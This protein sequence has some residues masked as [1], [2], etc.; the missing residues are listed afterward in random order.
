MLY[1]VKMIETFATATT[2]DAAAQGGI[3]FMYF[4]LP[5]IILAISLV[6]F[7]FWCVLTTALVIAAGCGS[8]RGLMNTW[9]VILPY[10]G[11]VGMLLGLGLQA[12]RMTSGGGRL[13]TFDFTR[14]Q[15]RVVPFA[16]ALV[17]FAVLTAG[18]GGVYL[19][20]SGEK[21]Q[22]SDALFFAPMLLSAASSRM[23]ISAFRA[24]KW[25]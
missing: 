15:E 16:G 18:L 1:T 19:A 25:L 13:K 14:V 2:F 11:T 24:Q 7:L 5:V 23:A 10:V 17:V 8:F 3:S 22:L 9:Y 6:P 4:L 20:L 21:A 12:V